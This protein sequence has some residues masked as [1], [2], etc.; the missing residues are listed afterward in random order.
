MSRADC[1]ANRANQLGPDPSVRSR[2]RGARAG[3]YAGEMLFGLFAPASVAPAAFF[4]QLAWV[5]NGPW[6]SRLRGCSH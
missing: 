1:G 3:L 4:E 2:L 5:A 6:G